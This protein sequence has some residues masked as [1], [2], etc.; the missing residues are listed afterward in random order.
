MSEKQDSWSKPLIRVRD[1]RKVYAV[2]EERVVALD[3]INLTIMQG[4]TCCIFGTSGS[5]KSTLLS[6]LAG[7]E[8]PS[9]GD[10]FIGNSAISRMPE[11]D[12]A[13]FRQ[14]YLGFIFQSYNL[15]PQLTAVENVALPL[16][17]RGIEKHVRNRM[18]VELL[19][20][21]GLRHRLT[22]YPGQMSGG[23]Q[24]RVGIARAFINRPK[25]VFADEPT[26]NLDTRTTGEVLH[27]MK[28]FAAEFNETLIL[29]TH[30]PG[31]QTYADR[32]VTLRDG[33][34]ISNIKGGQP[35]EA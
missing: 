8:K 1:L 16:A 22:H 12:L 19:K 21:V 27:M 10:V 29:V 5:G 11:A 14:R 30:D 25:V 4:E 15:L 2:G 31:I 3:K 20:R 17:F 28:E 33:V 32:V 13:I 24:Q 9:V 18:A 34:V 7:M 26:G 35:D 23:R 6:Q